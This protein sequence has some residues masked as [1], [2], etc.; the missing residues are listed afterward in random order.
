MENINTDPSC[1]ATWGQK[2]GPWSA[3]IISLCAILLIAIT[4]LVY[5]PL[6]MQSLLAWTIVAVVFVL[7]YI[8]ENQPSSM[9][10]T[11][12]CLLSLFLTV[13]YLSFRATDTLFFGS[14][15]DAVAVLCLF[16]AEAYGAAVH[17]FGLFVNISP[18]R[19][20]VQPVD[21]SRDDLPSVDIFI[22]TYNEAEEIVTANVMACTLLEYP[23]DKYSIF[24]L[25]DGGTWEK[26]ASSDPLVASKAEKRHRQL[27]NLAHRFGATYL[28]REK[29]IDAKAGNLTQALACT[30]S[31]MEK[32]SGVLERNSCI[33]LGVRQT[34]AD[35]I[36]ILDCDHIPTQDILKNTVSPFLNDP[37]LFL[38][39]TPHFFV[40]PDPMEKNLGTTGH[41]PGENEMF[42][43]AVHHGLD[44]WNASFF[45]G[46]AAV[47]RRRYLVEIGGIQGSTI[48]EDAETSLALHSKGLRSA[49]IGK[50][51]VCGLSPD[52]FADF[53]LQR[54][55]WT[56]G[57]IQIFLLKNPLWA[58]GLSLPQRLCYFN[59]CLFWFFGLARVVFWF[60][61]LLFLF[62]G[63][64][65]YNATLEQIAAYALPHLVAAFLVSDFMFGK[66]RH[67]FFS[68]LY[69]T[70]QSIFLIPAIISAAANPRSP[71]FKVTPKGQNLSQDFLSPLAV[72]LY[73][74]LVV[75]ICAYPFGVWR[76]TLSPLYQDA[77]LLCMAWTTF[78]LIMLL[79][80]LGVVWERR[81]L[82]SRHRIAVEE[83]VQ[84]SS[85]NRSDPQ[86]ATVVDISHSGVR[87]RLPQDVQVT[88]GDRL[89]MKAQ[90]ARGHV[91]SL[92]LETVWVQN[93]N[94]I[95][96][97][98]CSFLAET[99]EEQVE[100]VGY[101][102]GDSD[103]WER[104]WQKRRRRI[105]FL[106]SSL[107]LLQKGVTGTTR[108]FLG[109]FHLSTVIMTTAIKDSVLKCIPKVSKK[110]TPS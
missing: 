95:L 109:L 69:E 54:S 91:Y 100:I 81:Q 41:G 102:F 3:W 82:R 26:R 23:K 98:G 84:V 79:L 61:P 110:G 60:S 90:D 49:Y 21:L 74:M 103:R 64:Q 86:E 19:R 85:V 46:S 12:I 94:G 30:C 75:T 58:K 72:P 44:S 5:L 28:T 7:R 35:L 27:Q 8:P 17:L 55:R 32:F 66:V 36:L 4:F 6:Q 43:G 108:N 33:N 63:L 2:S 67:P 70:V 77:T 42:Y 96:T 71:T 93:T 9:H 29:N 10:R 99:Q 62:F 52:T 15:P 107:Y 97:V 59:S 18:L 87:L 1:N 37:E 76:W 88:A 51:M 73:L 24:I 20:P 22:P 31:D 101:V 65:V 39:Q 83:T 89:H 48:T 78:N 92:R 40:N 104:Y 57:M 11:L 47:I 105:G 68:E 25:D 106:R 80:A 16:S 50:P 38:V 13:R 56:Q 53:I 34:C 14:I 45:C